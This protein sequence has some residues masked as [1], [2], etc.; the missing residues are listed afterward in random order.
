MR[1][2]EE[3]EAAI[4]EILTQYR[5]RCR[6]V[7]TMAIGLRATLYADARREAIDAIFV[8]MRPSRKAVAT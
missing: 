8:A 1:R 4:A 6:A 7:A 5:E 2:S 3:R